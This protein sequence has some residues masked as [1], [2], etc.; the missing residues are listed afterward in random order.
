MEDFEPLL[1]L[2]QRFGQAGLSAVLGLLAKEV[3]EK[4]RKKRDRLRSK[5]LQT[6]E[7]LQS[8]GLSRIIR[9][10]SRLTSEN[11]EELLDH[12]CE[13]YQ[14]FYGTSPSRIEM[15]VSFEIIR[16]RLGVTVGYWTLI[17]QGLTFPDE[18]EV[19]TSYEQDTEK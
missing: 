12:F 13:E 15:H 14:Q 10:R 1:R 7:K 2:L 9:S 6:Q 11:L 19:D 3:L 18:S 5:P 4:S 16:S 17:I 8:R